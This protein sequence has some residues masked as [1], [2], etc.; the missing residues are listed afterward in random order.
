MG[1]YAS[2]KRS[3]LPFRT[4]ALSRYSVWMF[5]CLGLALTGCATNKTA[6]RSEAGLSKPTI[7][8]LPIKS[9]DPVVRL[10]NQRGRFI[11]YD[12]YNRSSQT[13]RGLVMIFEGVDCDG[14]RPRR[15]WQLSVRRTLSIGRKHSFRHRLPYF[16]HHVKVTAFGKKKYE[17]FKGKHKPFV[18]YR[19]VPDQRRVAYKVYN[20]SILPFRGLTVLI[21]GKDCDGPR[22]SYLMIRSSRAWLRPGYLRSFERVMPYPCRRFLVRAFD[23]IVFNRLRVQM[24]RRL[25]RR[26]RMQRRKQPPISQE[27]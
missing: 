1:M 6:Q 11:R 18:R 24:M 16:C 15:L 5:L 21:L 27:I 17:S 8:P 3:H 12:V 2:S 23:R 10:L 26:R 7:E 19:F 22:A 25:Q 14:V 20:R 4:Q 9:P 13:F